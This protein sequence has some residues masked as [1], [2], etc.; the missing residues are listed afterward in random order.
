MKKNFLDTKGN[1]KGNNLGK[2]FPKHLH[3]M[4]SLLNSQKKST[5][6]LYYKEKKVIEKLKETNSQKKYYLKRNEKILESIQKN[7]LN[8][9]QSFF[10]NHQIEK[11]LNEAKK[12]YQEYLNNISEEIKKEINSFLIKMRNIYE[13][14]RKK[15]YNAKNSI[16]IKKE[17]KITL[18]YKINKLGFTVRLFGSKFFQK[19]KNNCKLI[20]NGEESNLKE[21]YD[22]K[23]IDNNLEILKIFII[24][25]N[26]ITDLS[27]MF[28]GCSSLISLDGISELNTANINNMSH[29]FYNCSSIQS[30]PNISKWEMS[31]VINISYMFAG[32]S[33][34]ENLPDISKWNIK[35]VVDISSIFSDRSSLK[36]IPEISK[37][38]TNNIKDMSFIFYGCSSLILLPDISKWNTEKVINLKSI[39]SF[40]TSLKSIPN[41]SKWNIDN[42]K[43]ISYMFNGC[44]SLSYLPDISDWNTKNVT[45]IS[46]LFCKCSS[47]ILLPN[48][49]KWETNRITDMSFLFYN[50]LSLKYIPDIFKW[51]TSQVLNMS[52]MFYGCSNLIYLPDIS[53]W[54]TSN[55]NNFSYMFYDCSSLKYLPNISKWNVSNVIEIKMMFAHCYSLQSIPNFSN[56]NIPNNNEIKK[57]KNIK[58][59]KEIIL[60]GSIKNDILK[61]IPQIEIKFNSVDEFDE[62]TISSLKKEL[63][64]II[65]ND[66][67]SII[68][69]KKG[70]LKILIT[71][72]YLFHENMNNFTEETLIS[73]SDALDN[74]SKNINEEMEKL[75]SQLKNHEF[76]SLGSLRPDYVDKEIFNLSDESNK[77]MISEKIFK[78]TRTDKK[79]EVNLYEASK[80]I[81]KK[82]FEN[83]FKRISLEAEEQEKNMIRLIERLDEYNIVFD[84]EIEK[85]LKNSVFEYKIKHIFLVEK[86]NAQI[87]QFEKD[88]KRC[89]NRVDKILFHGTKIDN[90]I[91]II[92]SQFRDA[93]IVHQI[94]KGVYFTDSLDYI[95]FYAAE[96]ETEDNYRKY[97]N[98]NK[99]PKVG[100]SFSFVASE[101]YYNENKLEIVYDSRKEDE[102]V[103]KKGI[104]IAYDRYNTSILTK[105]QLQTFKGFFAKEFVISDKSQILPLYAVTV[106]RVEY[107]VIWRDYNFNEENPN[108]YNF[109]LFNEIQEFHRKIKKYISRE[110]NTKIYYAKNDE[111]AMKILDRKKYNKIIILTNGN[112]NGKDFIIKA[113]NI[114]GSNAIAAV[115]VYDIENHIN[116]VRN[117]ENVLILNGL[118][119]HK[120]FFECI[121]KKNINLFHNLKNEIINYYKDDIPN[122]DLNENTIS[123]FSFPNFKEGAQ[124][125]NRSSYA[126]KNEELF[127]NLNFEYNFNDYID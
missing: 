2:E 107:L 4:S 60:K 54:N 23:A 18:M 29:L 122:F 104:R 119:F 112:N 49:S 73:I 103:D 1:L 59:E 42:V 44:S 72:Q 102:Y 81:D 91:G 58:K 20:I 85:L 123:L 105:D 33:S 32:C 87:Y 98:I 28:Y 52:Y 46:Y 35:N 116:W 76:I 83:F 13:E 38:N 68:E 31:N 27:H 30:L 69:I 121:I 65:K 57:I 36:I 95:Y 3:Q 53:N 126:S 55:V 26:N 45:D 77:K 127:E 16:V 34:L 100:D 40:T 90:V 106:E 9:S 7:D 63:R 99:I 21:F 78:I 17:V 8:S 14:K 12:N 11:Q 67:F 61:Y 10:K 124:N 88:K 39:F 41:I 5:K 86:N 117:M 120:K 93:S 125:L 56:W 43:N 71:L 19:N 6:K 37:W 92:S 22:I 79:N 111:E 70:S 109:L 25:N 89:I 80:A 101:I 62:N 51:N 96:V 66:N 113:R 82:E 48:I 84:K 114:I 110:L 74:F 47:L 115:S 94:G 15:Y 24:L 75:S 50:C 118:D 97:R 64:K 108:N